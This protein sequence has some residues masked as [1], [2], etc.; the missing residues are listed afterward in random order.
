[1]SR[2]DKARLPKRQAAAHEDRRHSCAFFEQF[3]PT[4]QKEGKHTRSKSSFSCLSPLSSGCSS[5]RSAFPQS[6]GSGKTLSTVSEQSGD[7]PTA[8]NTVRGIPETWR[9][10]EPLTQLSK[11]AQSAARR[12]MRPIGRGILRSSTR[13]SGACLSVRG[14]GTHVRRRTRSGIRC[15]RHSARRC[16]NRP[17]VRRARFPLASLS[18]N[19][20]RKR[21]RVLENADIGT[22][23]ASARE[24]GWHRARKGLHCQQPTHRRA[25]YRGARVHNANRSNVRLVLWNARLHGRRD[26]HSTSGYDR[27]VGPLVSGMLCLETALVAPAAILLLALV[28]QFA[29]FGFQTA[30][31]DHAVNTAAWRITAQDALSPDYNAVVHAAIAADWMP[32]DGTCLTVSNAHIESHINE[33]SSPTNRP[34]DRDH[35]LVER[36]TRHVRTV[37]TKADAVYTIRPL[38]ALPLFEPVLLQRALDRTFVS[39]A[40]F[41]IS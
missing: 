32:I 5:T 8:R 11:L 27:P 28:A 25:R 33:E 31:F 7:R 10:L 21:K 12:R 40:R 9:P 2:H 3:R 34:N 17:F 24:R 13:S 41:E 14:S 6:K 16:L 35:F 37:R 22:L 15:S 18:A 39:D 36:T 38:A 4:S 23:P 29:W 19:C 26:R 20:K 30:C 1:M